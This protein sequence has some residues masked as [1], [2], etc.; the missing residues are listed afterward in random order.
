LQNPPMSSTSST[1]VAGLELAAMPPPAHRLADEETSWYPS[2][3]PQSLSSF[4][5]L[6]LLFLLSLPRNRPA[7]KLSHHDRRL[8]SLLGASP[9]SSKHSLRSASWPSSSPS[10]E[11]ARGGRNHQ[12]PSSFPRRHS[13][14]VLPNSPS[15]VLLQPNRPHR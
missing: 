3:V 13:S 6:I 14:S 4:P 9:T 7:P 15:S 1:C 8:P 2:P 10:T 12:R 11:S 5:P